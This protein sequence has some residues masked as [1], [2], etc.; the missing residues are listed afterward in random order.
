MGHF[1]PDI[2]ICSVRLGRGKRVCERASILVLGLCL[3]LCSRLP[4]KRSLDLSCVT[5][6]T[7]SFPEWTTN[8]RL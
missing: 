7:G 6:I 3:I 8:T 5:F 2:Y 1:V 4:S